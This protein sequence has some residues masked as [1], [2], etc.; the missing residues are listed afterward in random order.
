MYICTFN[1]PC[2]LISLKIASLMAISLTQQ[3]N[4]QQCKNVWQL[5]TNG[6]RNK[7]AIGN[8]GVSMVW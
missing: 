4:V 5:Y 3:G 7:Y 1:V 2:C 6:Q 8:L